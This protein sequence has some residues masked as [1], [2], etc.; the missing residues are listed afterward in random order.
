MERIAIITGI[1]GDVNA[2]KHVLNDIEERGIPEVYCLGNIVKPG[3]ENN[4]ECLSLVTD[5][6]SVILTGDN[7]ERVT[8]LGETDGYSLG[9]IETIDGMK[10]SH[11]F[12][13]SGRL[14]RVFYSNPYNSLNTT[15]YACRKSELFKP[16]IRTGRSNA[17]VVIYSDSC[18]TLEQTSDH[19]TLIGVQNV[20]T[21]SEGPTD[22]EGCCSNYVI[23]EGKKDSMNFDQISYQCVKV[24]YCL[25][26][27]R[28]LGP[29]KTIGTIGE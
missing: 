19:R 15:A 29:T 5:R 27:D 25:D 21:S 17:D 24:F 2:L 7:E 26:V 16:S 4:S 20:S 12:Y 22:L 10:F 11:Q 9:D 13:M 23:I 18:G 3:E 1:N 28:E 14:I 8:V 6:C